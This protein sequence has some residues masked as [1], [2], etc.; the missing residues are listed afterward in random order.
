MMST[1][2]I[3]HT[4]YYTIHLNLST[5]PHLPSQSY[6]NIYSEFGGPCFHV[7]S[8]YKR[9]V[10]IFYKGNEAQI[11]LQNL[12]YVAHLWATSWSVIEI[13]CWFA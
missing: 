9:R 13:N 7:K 8:A 5:F 2:I 3:R 1:K 4:I 6:W 10:S 12:K 11:P